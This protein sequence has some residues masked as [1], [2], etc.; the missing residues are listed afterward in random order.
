[1][2]TTAN[3]SMIQQAMTAAGA[4]YPKTVA[5]AIDERAKLTASAA[6]IAQ[7]SADD[8][9]AAVADAII[10]GRDPLEDETVR[11]LTTARAIAG[12]TGDALRGGVDRAAETRIIAAMTTEADAIITA[13]R[14]AIADAGA[15][16]A[17]SWR[18]LGDLELNDSVAVLKMGPDASRAWTDARDAQKRIRAIDDGWYG[19]A[20]LTRFA[21]SSDPKTLRLADVNLETFEKLGRTAEPWAIVRAGITLDLADRTT[22]RERVERLNIARQDRQAHARQKFSDQYRQARGIPA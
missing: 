3:L 19:L 12:P 16:L 17:A 9:A 18:I 2:S 5:K 14:T 11:R 21:S 7:P 8:V 15:T 13:F 22:I 20:E 4:T 6:A 10:G 1:M